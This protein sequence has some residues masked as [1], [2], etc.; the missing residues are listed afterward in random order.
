MS[1][2]LTTINDGVAALAKD[3]ALLRADS[4]AASIG[5][6]FR[7]TNADDNDIATAS[8]AA[9]KDGIARIEDGK[10]A[11]FAPY[12]EAEK[13]VTLYFGPLL[14]RLTLAVKRIDAQKVA[15]QREQLRAAE[16]QRRAAE[17]AQREAAEKAAAAAVADEGPD[18]DLPPP[19]PQAFVPTPP[20]PP[21]VSK[22]GDAKSQVRWTPVKCAIADG[23]RAERIREIAAKWPHLLALN[24]Q[25]AKAEFAAMVARG[26]FEQPSEAGTVVCGVR[27]W[28]DMSV[29]GGR[30]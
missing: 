13:R 16:E 30:G 4:E 3:D 27:F 26:D 11:L 15:F 18:E 20:P 28:R 22:M 2:D 1:L 7:V 19:T 10:K 9:I 6:D 8:R 14:D 5:P 21:A 25:I 17:R 29:S 24:E 23:D 12:K